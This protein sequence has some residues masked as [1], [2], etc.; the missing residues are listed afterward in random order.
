[1]AGTGPYLVR[2]VGAAFVTVLLIVTM[3]FVLFRAVPGDAADA[4][5]CRGCTR[6]FRMQVRH[7]LGLD[8]SLPAQYLIYLKQ[9]TRG[10]FGASLS[11]NAS[12]PVGKVV[13]PAIVNTLPLVA[14]AMLVSVVLG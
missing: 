3:N 11:L 9:L 7:Q 6:Q 2:R 5:S 13:G 10:D 4:L 12:E 1:M 14:L 8:Q